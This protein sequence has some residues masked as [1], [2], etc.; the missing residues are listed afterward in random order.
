MSRHFDIGP[1][2][3]DP[4]AHV[5]T[6]GD[7]PV[8]LGARGVAVLTALVSR[9]PEYVSKAS[10]LDAAWPGLVVEEANIA[11]QISSIRRALARAPGGEAWIETLARRGYRFVGPVTVHAGRAAEPAV[12]LDRTRTNLPQVL[13]SFVGRAR[14]IAE[15]KRL[16]PTTR[17]L[18]LTG[19]GGIGKT[20]L[21]LQAAA[22]VLDAYRDGVWFVDLAPLLDPALVPSAVAQALGVKEA[23]GQ[24]LPVTLCEY[25]RAKEMLLVL[26]NCEHVLGACA[27]L[28]DALLRATSRICVVATSRESLRIAGE[29][30]YPLD[31]LPVPA[32]NADASAIARSDAVQLF[33]DRARQHRARFDLEGSRASAVAAIC[34][35]LD[36]L[37]LALE[38]AAARVAMLPIEE[39][40]RLLDQRFRLLTRGGGGD[41]PRQQTLRAMIDWS[42]DLLGEA[43]RQLFAR[44]SVFAGGWTVA[45]AE[46]V[47]AGDPI[48]KD[49]VAYVLI[50]LIDKSLVVADENGDRYRMLE[51]VREYARDRLARSN[52]MPTVRARHRDYFLA[53]VE[54]AEPKLAGPDQ[55]EW[56]RHLDTEHDNIRSSLEWSDAGADASIALRFCG[57][58]QKFWIARGYLTEGR[59]CC[60]RAL[61]KA[62]SA[63][64]SAERA[65]VLNAAG[66]LAYLL[67][68]YGSARASHEESLAIRQTLGDRLGAAMSLGNLGIVA[69]FQGDYPL[70]RARQEENVAISRELGDPS[71]LA[72]ALGNLANV[73]L[74]QGDHSF[75]ESLLQE[76]LGIVRE[77]GDQGRIALTLH[78]L[79]KV[80]YDRHDYP[81]ALALLT[82]SL[83][84]KRAVGNW[85]SI[86]PGLEG[87]AIVLV[88][89]G[90]GLRAARLWGAAERM[91]EEMGTPVPPNARPEHDREVAD[92]RAS[93]ND[94]DAFG[95][96]WQ[97]GRD[98]SDEQ[99]LEL[100]LAATAATQ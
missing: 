84:L 29:Q 75:A 22:E 78:N 60:A 62:S 7:V 81:S 46:A 17:S 91:R 57:G 24:P 56:L 48:A 54:E 82:E 94:D 6:E 87:A 26:D 32:A 99:T 38:L 90:D 70:A 55:A 2:R 92:A 42:Y 50:A 77:T 86:P 5:L 45:A 85:M 3:L 97:E 30:T 36:G 69:Y 31:A 9:A 19:T 98:L 74:D 83:I 65:R 52:D 89:V 34:I 58:L 100:A 47:G 44:L 27:D 16:L 49:D 72:N 35:R 88:K 40:L 53:T 28:V 12:L 67:G 8:A 14:E 33:V 80:A 21:A 11:V 73:A 68:D 79:A 64:A 10:I 96:A 15:I 95:R 43:E 41:L 66:A 4:E 37:P 61:A 25:A 93:V 13:S 63:S 39:I 18:T 20:R 1:L 59:E 23:A 76:C 51:T 71:K